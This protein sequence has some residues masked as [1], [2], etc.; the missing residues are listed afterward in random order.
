MDKDEIPP[1]FKALDI[2]AKEMDYLSQKFEIRNHTELFSWGIKMLYD[3][4]KL[5]EGGWRLSFQKCDVDLEKRKVEY[6]KFHPIHFGSLHNLGPI[7]DGFARLPLSEDLDI[8]QK[9]KE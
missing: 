2:S 6:K 9:I 7:E 8:S 1:G 4:T 3:I 5:D